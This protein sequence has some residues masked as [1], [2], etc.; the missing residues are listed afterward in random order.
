[1][2]NW[3]I[4]VCFIVVNARGL[5]EAPCNEACLVFDK[6]AVLKFPVKDPLRVMTFVSAGRST[7]VK[8]FRWCIVSISKSIAAIHLFALGALSA[9]SIDHRSCVARVG[10][11]A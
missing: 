8:T 6:C 9:S 2:H 7:V 11:N 10:S 3:C 4:E 1:M 5:G